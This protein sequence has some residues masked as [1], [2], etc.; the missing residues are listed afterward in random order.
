MH[1]IFRCVRIVHKELSLG[2]LVT[3]VKEGDAMVTYEGLFALI[4]I[5]IA[6]ITLCHLV[7]K[8]RDR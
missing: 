8:D 5:I 6:V 3:L 7:F 2:G 4:M 1:V